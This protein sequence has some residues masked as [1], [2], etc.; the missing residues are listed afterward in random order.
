MFYQSFN[1]QRINQISESIVG[2]E[3]HQNKPPSFIM[4]P[5]GEHHSHSMVIE[6]HQVQEMIG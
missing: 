2:G 3:N 4:H 1:N 6:Y 5:I